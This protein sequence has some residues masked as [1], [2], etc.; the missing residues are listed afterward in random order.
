MPQV[1]GQKRSPNKMAG[2]VKSR[3]QSNPK[4]TRHSEGSNKALSARGPRD[5]TRHWGRSAFECLSVSC[6][7]TDR[8]SGYS[9]PGRCG[10]WHKPFWRRQPLSPLP[11]H[12]L[13]RP[14]Y[15]E[16][17]QPHPSTENWIKDYWTLTIKARPRF[18]HSQSLPLGASGSL[19]SLSIRGQTEWKPQSQKTLQTDHM[20]HLLV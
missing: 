19:L 4:P 13:A 16:G 8:G 18:P 17:T 9:R 12:S 6:G 15:K 7:C 10:M 14:N 1:Q 11:Y 3:L 20:D 2:E 5:P